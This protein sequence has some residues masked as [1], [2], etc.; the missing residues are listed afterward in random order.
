MTIQELLS[1]AVRAERLAYMNHAGTLRDTLL[2]Y[3]E[4]VRIQAGQTMKEQSE[5]TPSGD[6]VEP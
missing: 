3:A 5:T 6:G 4:E 2:A 1:H